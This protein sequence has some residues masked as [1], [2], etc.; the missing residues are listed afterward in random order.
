MLYVLTLLFISGAEHSIRFKI[1]NYDAETRLG[2]IFH[3]VFFF[4]FVS[5]IEQY[6]IVLLLYYNNL[7]IET[8]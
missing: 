8:K 2:Y 6:I 3:R 4:F 7:F 5:H 1:R